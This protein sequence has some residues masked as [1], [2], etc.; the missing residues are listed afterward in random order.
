MLSVG[1]ALVAPLALPTMNGGLLDPAGSGV[2][3]GSGGGGTISA[4]NPLVSLRDSLNVNEDRQ[5]LSVRSDS[6]NVSDLYLRIVSLD[7]FDGTT[8]KRSERCH[9]HGARRRFPHSGRP[10]PGHRAR[11]DR[12]DDLD[13][14]LV[15]AGLAADAVSAERRGHQ[16]QLALRTGRDD[17]GRRPR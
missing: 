11:G 5:V 16:G 14:R 10:R 3:P 13:R 7:D 6:E 2:G 1:I 12:H 4:V 8:W 9:H 15:R 17:A